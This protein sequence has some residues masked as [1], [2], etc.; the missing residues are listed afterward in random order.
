MNRK[1][2]RR[3]EGTAYEISPRLSAHCCLIGGPWGKKKAP[4][5]GRPR[6]LS[7]SIE[8]CEASHYFKNIYRSEDNAMVCFM[9]RKPGRA[10][11]LAAASKQANTSPPPRRRVRTQTQSPRGG[12]GASA[13]SPAPRVDT[14]CGDL[15]FRTLPSPSRFAAAGAPHGC[16]SAPQ[17]HVLLLGV[18]MPRPFTSGHL[19]ELSCALMTVSLSLRSQQ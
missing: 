12:G 19:G 5:I 15:S 17:D 16:R 1:R 9:K 11:P 6:F 14:G 8:L 10:N 18:V 7:S 3:Q 2:S 13:P 4:K